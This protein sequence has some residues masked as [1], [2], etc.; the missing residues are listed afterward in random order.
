MQNDASMVS[1]DLPLANITQKEL[2][3]PGFNTLIP[4]FFDTLIPHLPKSKNSSDVTMLVSS[5]H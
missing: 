3:F 5:I 2:L 1:Q 4:L